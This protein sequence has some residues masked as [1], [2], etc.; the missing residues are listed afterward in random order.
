MDKDIIFRIITT[1]SYSI[2]FVLAVVCVTV[3]VQYLRTGFTNP[4][5]AAEGLKF[6]EQNLVITEANLDSAYI[7]ISPTNILTD[8]Q[9]ENDTEVREIEIRVK[10]NDGSVVKFLEGENEVT[11]VITHLDAPIKLAV[12]INEDDGLPVGGSCKVSAYSTDGMFMAKEMTI[13]VD[14]P[15]QDINVIIKNKIGQDVT[16]QVKEDTIRFIKG[17]ELYFSVETIPARARQPYLTAQQKNPIFPNN[18]IRSTWATLDTIG[19]LNVVGDDSATTGKID[20]TAKILKSYGLDESNDEN[21]VI[22]QF[23][24]ETARVELNTIEIRNSN[25]DDVDNERLEIFVG[26]SQ[27]VKISARA[28]GLSDVINLNMFLKPTYYTE[29]D[30]PLYS[31][32]VN[33]TLTAEIER[34]DHRTPNLALIEIYTDTVDEVG[35]SALG[36]NIMWTIVVNRALETSETVMLKFGLEGQTVTRYLKIEI[37]ESLP[38]NGTI[39]GKD[40]NFELAKATHEGEE[41]IDGTNSSTLIFEKDLTD[42]LT[43]EMDTDVPLTYTKFVYFL[44]EVD[45]IPWKNSTGSDIVN[46]SQTGQI[47]YGTGSSATYSKMVE[48]K[49]SG[50]VVVDAYLVLTDKNGNA[51]DCNY[52]VIKNQEGG[53]ETAGLVSRADVRDPNFDYQA[54]AHNYVYVAVTNKKFTITVTEKLTSLKF[55]YLLN[56]EIKDV[57]NMLEMGTGAEN[58]L[59]VYIE[60]NSM[61]ALVDNW[62]NF[63]VTEPSD[64]SFSSNFNPN[65]D[66]LLPTTNQETERWTA[67]Q[68]PVTITALA[69]DGKGTTGVIT[70]SLGEKLNFPLNLKSSIV[71]ID[72]ITFDYEFNT[73]EMYGYKYKYIDLYGQVEEITIKEATDN[74]AAEKA[75]GIN[76]YTTET[77]TSGGETEEKYEVLPKANYDVSEEDKAKGLMHP[78]M[79]SSNAFVYELTKAELEA[80][81]ATPEIWADPTKGS[82]DYDFT[83]TKFAV[84]VQTGQDNDRISK[85]LVKSI[86]IEENKYYA[87]VY[88]SSD[89]DSTVSNFFIINFHPPVFEYTAGTE[90][91]EDNTVVFTTK[92]GSGADASN[93]VYP[94]SRNNNLQMNA[95]VFSFSNFR[96]TKDLTL[97]V[98]DRMPSTDNSD[99]TIRQNSLNNEWDFVVEENLRE[100][101]ISSGKGQHTVH[102]ANGKKASVGGS[103]GTKVKYINVTAT[104]PIY[105]SCVTEV[106]NGVSEATNFY[107]YATRT[108]TICWGPL[109]ED[110]YYITAI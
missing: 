14:V 60:A 72:S 64:T 8:E 18:E 46:I 10:V 70:F 16:Q 53:E 105:L 52:N 106:N 55:T 83:T 65:D 102:L 2:C 48:A 42:F 59:T 1:V 107:H 43:F 38:R 71:L 30:D 26:E 41:Y 35:S 4:K 49:G 20:L 108:V 96:S 61:Y 66:M 63:N 87:V 11:E 62:Q 45:N 5:V 25:Y 9:L 56:N 109:N 31:N 24:I 22:S 76:W 29:G 82:P 95:V 100:Y 81:L 19:I 23:S 57:G 12:M 99:Y 51:I 94:T 79:P 3:F 44:N 98:T 54:L 37:E 73:G 13:N 93:L 34:G 40:I 39:E 47:K 67:M 80:C 58:A 50:T 104:M 89:E 7:T 97:I 6:G 103:T 17:D 90:I 33:L 110:G 84:G 32:I 88:L 21:Y 77:A 28:T 85:L 74:E 92:G 86:D 27:S 101:F 36:T 68:L 78:S 75:W 69:P 15:I 91:T